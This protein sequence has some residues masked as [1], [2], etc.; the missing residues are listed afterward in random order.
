MGSALCFPV[1]AMVFLTV[2]FLGIERELGAPL[3]R[4]TLIKRFGKQVRVF[5]DDLIVPRDYVLSVVGELENFGFRVNTSKSFWT[6]RF[7]ESCGRQYFDGQDVSIV[8][9]RQVLPTRRQDA[10][11]VISAAEYRNLAYMA[12]LWKTAA[13]MDD[14][15]RKLLLGVYPNVAPSSPLLGRV[16][17]LGYEFQRTDPNTF[18]PLTKGYYK[19]AKAPEDR[20]SG[21]GA[22]LKCLLQKED[23]ILPFAIDVGRGKPEM[24]HLGLRDIDEEHL[25][26]S[27]R[28][29][30]VNIKLGWR[31]PY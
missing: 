16:S 26:R 25:E 2:I 30:Y 4:R 15:L 8:K 27:G 28:P 1:E 22:L 11:G 21:S 18:G 12:G 29:E 31:P 7:R 13:W 20:I 5:G 6:G 24:A 14:Y 17:F 23:S 10:S 3:S 19:R 9:V